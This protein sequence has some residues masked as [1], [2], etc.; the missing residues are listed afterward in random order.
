MD[1]LRKAIASTT[2]FAPVSR[3]ST[4]AALEKT[5]DRNQVLAALHTD[6]MVSI[7]G[8][9]VRGDSAVF[10]I[11]VWDGG[12]LPQFGNRSFTGPPTPIG[13]PLARA[14]SLLSRAVLM[15]MDV[16]HAP[17]IPH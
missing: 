9:P 13:A 7:R 17:R 2:R 1:V 6:M 4:L 14:D 5:R 16:D 15:L 10:T 8:R 11:T 12:A 3:D